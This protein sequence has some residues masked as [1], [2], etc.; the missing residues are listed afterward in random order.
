L[1]RGRAQSVGEFVKIVFVVQNHLKI[2]Q[3]DAHS[4]AQVAIQTTLGEVFHPASPRVV[5]SDKAPAI[6]RSDRDEVPI[7]DVLAS[8]FPK[9]RLVEIYWRNISLLSARLGCPECQLT[10]IVTLH[11][12]AHALVHLGAAPCSPHAFPNQARKLLAQRTRWFS[13]LESS[14]NEFLAQVL[15][16]LAIH[17]AARGSRMGALQEPFLALMPKQPAEYRLT[18]ETTE[19]LSPGGAFAA[20][21]WLREPRPYPDPPSGVPA[22]VVLCEI[23][24]RVGVS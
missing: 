24:T 8:Y 12:F 23:A 11:E 19:L 17:G 15:A 9:R 21:Q 10:D 3:V 2:A 18:K 1:R 13:R 16:W 6:P 4:D 14:T 22:V 20:L 7:D 5:L